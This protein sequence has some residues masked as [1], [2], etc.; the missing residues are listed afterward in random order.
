[1]TFDSIKFDHSSEVVFA[2]ETVVG[3]LSM[4]IPGSPTA[5]RDSESLDEIEVCT[6]THSLLFYL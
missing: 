1:M 6:S 2:T 5:S 3:T 4:S